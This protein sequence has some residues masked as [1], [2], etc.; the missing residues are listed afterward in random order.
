MRAGGKSMK[1]GKLFSGGLLFLL[2]LISTNFLGLNSSLGAEGLLPSKSIY[3]SK[4]Q[5]D[6]Q[7]GKVI[8]LSEL[9]GT[10][11]I[12]AML[13]TSCQ[14]SCPLTIADL[15]AIEKGLST[16]DRAKVRFAV[17][18]FDSKKDTSKALKAFSLKQ[19]VDLSHWSFFHGSTRSVRELAALL[20]I[21]FKKLDSGDYDHSNVITVLDSEGVIVHQ[22][23][24]VRQNPQESIQTLKK[25]TSIGQGK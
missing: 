17:F 11:I 20:G 10:P 19:G 12:V 5:F 14:A 25:L 22:Q 16:E 24:G 23:I 13:Y 15:K 4:A 1:H 18:S 7:E 8:S 3:Q 2:S 21:K 6:N 9:R